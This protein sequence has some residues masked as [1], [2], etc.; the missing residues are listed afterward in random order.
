MVAAEEVWCIGMEGLRFSPRI[1]GRL[2]E[3]TSESPVKECSCLRMQF[4]QVLQLLLFIFSLQL[5]KQSPKHCESEISS[6]IAVGFGRVNEVSFAAL[7]VQL[8]KINLNSDYSSTSS[9]VHCSDYTDRNEF[10][11]CSYSLLPFVKLKY[12][13]A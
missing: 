6:V 5:I 7:N 13:G 9:V 11:P 12:V 2:S 8:F 1:T 4:L 10:A 3:T